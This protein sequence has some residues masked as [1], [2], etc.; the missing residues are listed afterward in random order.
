MMLMEPRMTAHREARCTRA[1]P[2]LTPAA[3][4]ART[5]DLQTY[6][7]VPPAADASF[8]ANAFYD[9]LG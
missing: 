4:P 7:M 6:L 9:A 2:L 5:P 1:A 8:A 3:L